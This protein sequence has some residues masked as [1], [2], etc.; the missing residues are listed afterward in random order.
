M[1]V[2][3]RQGATPHVQGLDLLGRGAADRL[4]VALADHEIV[5]DE[6]PERAERQHVASLIARTFD[7]QN[8]PVL[9]QAHLQVIGSA[10]RP[11]R[12]E[13]IGL[14]EIEDRDLAL[15]L[16]VARSR[17]ERS[18]VDLDALET[19]VVVLLGHGSRTDRAQDLLYCK[20]GGGVIPRRRV[21]RH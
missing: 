21:D 7:I 8:K 6:G 15:L 17:G 14:Q 9:G 1:R 10:V 13:T 16:L 20:P 5:L 11:L 4:I 3:R 19:M 12:C 18:V 2:K